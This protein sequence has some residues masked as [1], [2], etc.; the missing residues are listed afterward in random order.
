[1]Y[2]IIICAQCILANRVT[3]SETI[4]L[5]QQMNI[6]SHS[7]NVYFICVHE[8]FNI[9]RWCIWLPGKINVSIE[10]MWIG[11]GFRYFFQQKIQN[12]QLMISTNKRAQ[13]NIGLFTSC[14]NKLLLKFI[15]GEICY[16]SLATLRERTHIYT[17]ISIIPWPGMLFDYQIFYLNHPSI[18]EHL[19]CLPYSH[20]SEGGNIV[21]LDEFGPR[22]N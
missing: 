5:M 10:S 9:I 4:R 15:W 13:T 3:W 16:M 7:E 21:S 12:V 22:A 18:I 11:W 17:G 6:S 2:V 19:W 1:M 8:I 20:Q 14:L